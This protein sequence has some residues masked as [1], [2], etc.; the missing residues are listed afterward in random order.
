ML[1]NL[2]RILV[3]FLENTLELLIFVYFRIL[4]IQ[5]K[6]RDLKPKVPPV[7][8]FRWESTSKMSATGFEPVTNGLK[9]HCSAV[10]LRARKR[11]AF[12]HARPSTS[13]ER[14]LILQRPA[15]F[16]PVL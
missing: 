3:Q 2:R 8:S 4:K 6:A 9:G 15:C 16:F 13:T 7:S 10:E 14:A 12:Y 5:G 11:G 1:T